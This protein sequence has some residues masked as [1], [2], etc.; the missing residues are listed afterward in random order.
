MVS[1][2]ILQVPIFA[3]IVV[4]GFSL[5]SLTENSTPEAMSPAE[6]Y[7][8]CYSKLTLTPVPL[9]DATLKSLRE[10][11]TIDAAET[12]CLDIL[13]KGSLGIDG[14]LVASNDSVARAVLSTMQ[15]VHNS[16]FSAQTIG[17]RRTA[18]ENRLI[19][20]VDEPALYWT[21]G[22]F[23]E[24]VRADSVLTHNKALRSIRVRSNDGGATNFQARSFYNYPGV[25]LSETLTQRDPLMRLQFMN[26]IKLNI[27][28]GDNY[29]TMDIPDSSLQSFGEIIGVEDQQPLSIKRL[30]LPVIEDAAVNTQLRDPAR[31][32]NLDIDL[33]AHFGG[34]VL[35]SIMYGLKNSNLLENQLANGYTMIDRRFASRVFKDLLC[36]QLPVLL[37]EDVDII[38][39]SNF[40]FQQNK[41]CMQ[42]HATID[43][44]AMIQKNYVWASSSAPS[45]AFIAD[46]PPKGAEILTRFKLPVK[47]T[48]TVF[49]LGEPKGTLHFRTFD[50]KLVKIPITSFADVGRELAKNEDFYT[51]AAKRYYAYFTGIDVPLG[52]SPKDAV[53]KSHLNEVKELGAQLKVDQ[54]LKKLLIGILRSKAF[55]SRNYQTQGG[56][57]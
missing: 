42:C 29:S 13:N 44:F 14:K 39:N 11:G 8:R 52:E 7:A 30:I 28:N 22:L 51:C 19:A 21:R 10:Q 56:V 46:K 33:H 17:V 2:R 55:Q 5:T 45:A 34:G 50:G 32:P 49:A 43:E 35:G 23:R 18:F 53:E 37:P 36:Y 41:S 38:E 12:A 47:S 1:G 40:P 54:S 3:V 6:I 24:G 16:W 31:G 26:D 15:F 4:L 57:K 9:E 20:D 48:S 27:R 25:A